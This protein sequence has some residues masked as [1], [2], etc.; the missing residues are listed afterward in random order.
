MTSSTLAAMTCPKCTGE[1][2]T[3][4]RSGVH[5][6]QCRDCRGLFLDR[7]ELERLIDLEAA[8]A[9]PPPA[10]TRPEREDRQAPDRSRDDASRD[11]RWTDVPATG[12]GYPAQASAARPPERRSERGEGLGDLAELGGIAGLGS[13]GELGELFERER[14]HQSSGHDQRNA[15]G[16]PQRKRGGLFRELFEGFGD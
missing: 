1:M 7:G 8:F 13:L 10:W 5:V 9:G 11:T 2:R 14:R 4:E 6:D 3:Y 16:Q 15:Q 12:G